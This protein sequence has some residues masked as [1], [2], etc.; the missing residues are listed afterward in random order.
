MNGNI[1]P[2]IPLTETELKIRYH[3]INFDG[4]GFGF[5]A[6][7]T[8]NKKKKKNTLK[9]AEWMASFLLKLFI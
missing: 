7:H 3:Y 6:K 4:R 2:Q 5:T 9:M 1:E 8:P